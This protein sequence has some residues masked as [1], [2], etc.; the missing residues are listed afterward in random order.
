PFPSRA[1]VQMVD[2]VSR[3]RSTAEDLF[4]RVVSAYSHFAYR[5]ATQVG[6]ST[7]ARHKVNCPKGKR[8]YSEV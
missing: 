3:K 4:F 7:Q 1:W 5:T 6:Y 2:C 8:R